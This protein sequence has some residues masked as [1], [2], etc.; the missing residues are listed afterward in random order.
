[1]EHAGKYTHDKPESKVRFKNRGLLFFIMR[2]KRFRLERFPKIVVSSFKAVLPPAFRFF[3]FL[4][5]LGSALASA[6]DG[7]TGNVGDLKPSPDGFDYLSSYSA[8]WTVAANGLKIPL[9]LAKGSKVLGNGLKFGVNVTAPFPQAQLGKLKNVSFTLA[10]DKPFREIGTGIIEFDVKNGVEV[11]NF[12]DILWAAHKLGV[13]ASIVSNSPRKY[14]IVL[15]GFSPTTPLK[16]GGFVFD[17]TITYV[18]TTSYGG[19]WDSGVFNNTMHDLSYLPMYALSVSDVIDVRYSGNG[20]G[21]WYAPVLFNQSNTTFWNNVSC[22]WYENKGGLRGQAALLSHNFESDSHNTAPMY[23]GGFTDSPYYESGVIGS[24]QY[25]DNNSYSQI[26]EYTVSDQGNKSGMTVA[27]WLKTNGNPSGNN[28]TIAAIYDDTSQDILYIKHVGSSGGGAPQNSVAVQNGSTLAWRGWDAWSNAL[29]SGVWT[30]IAVTTNMTGAYIYV[31][32]VPQ[33]NRNLLYP[34]VHGNQYVYILG[35]NN[36]NTAPAQFNGTLDEFQ[37]L[38]FS[39]TPDE[40][41]QLYNW[42]VSQTQQGYA[43]NFTNVSISAHYKNATITVINQS[44]KQGLRAWWDLGD[45]VGVDANLNPNEFGLIN[46]YNLYSTMAPVVVANTCVTGNC[47]SLTT[48]GYY[49]NSLPAHSPAYYAYDSPWAWFKP[50]AGDLTGQYHVFGNQYQVDDGGAGDW[51]YFYGVGI[52]LRNGWIVCSMPDYAEFQME[53]VINSSVHATANQWYMAG[54]DLSNNNASIFVNG[55]RKSFVAGSRNTNNM[56]GSTSC[57]GSEWSELDY[58]CETYKFG[59]WV[60]GVMIYDW[61]ITDSLASRLYNNGCPSCAGG[62]ESNFTAWTPEQYNNCN[63][64]LNN[65]SPFMQYRLSLGYK[66]G[67]ATGAFSAQILNV[68]ISY[69]YLPSGDSTA[70]A[71]S[72]NQA[73]STLA[74]QA[75]LFNVTWS[76]E[77]A[78]G[79]WIFEFDNGTGSFVNYS[80]NFTGGLNYSTFTALLHSAYNATIKWRFYAVDTQGLMNST[81]LQTIQTDLPAGM[82]VLMPLMTKVLKPGGSDDYMLTFIITFGLACLFFLYFYVRIDRAYQERKIADPKAYISYRQQFNRYLCF[83]LSVFCLTLMMYFSWLSYPIS[84]LES[85]NYSWS[86]FTAG[87]VAYPVVNAT[88]SSSS[89]VMNSGATGMAETAFEIFLYLGLAF[90]IMFGVTGA[91]RYVYSMGETFSKKQQGDFGDE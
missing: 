19:Y 66:G 37:I 77:T 21:N 24:A 52:S 15:S 22:N 25:F 70:P 76:D 84:T 54:C 43:H 13:S 7:P 33:T 67:A 9:L 91:I 55:V 10:S 61:N 50:T 40:V 86:N 75:T 23:T 31:N 60:D 62:L 68:S 14:S 5:L 81:P 83:T 71:W 49:I 63:A 82:V 16:N 38:N 26:F 8:N 56:G 29:V 36:S 53:V 46:S 11:W 3:I 64:T 35:T 85:V 59:G 18:G 78:L 65:A 51:L 20:S 79:Y 30:H 69:N 57:V 87:T 34:Q 4:L 90:V 58:L 44:Q 80:S 2:K 47:A 32:G 88:L 73:N 12:G 17:P 39:A 45:T 72:N 42:D 89:L 1:M 74:G 28:R 6:K 27:F 41:L 48:G